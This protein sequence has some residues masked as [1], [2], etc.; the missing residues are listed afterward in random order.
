M[1]VIGAGSFGRTIA[2]LL[3]INSNVLLYS[4]SPLSRDVENALQTSPARTFS[5][6]NTTSIKDFCRSCKVIFPIV[7]SANFRDMTRSF[8]SELHP[9]HILIHGTKGFD[10]MGMDHSEKTWIRRSNMR[11][12]SQVIR[13][14]TQVVRIGCMSGPNL[15]VEIEK[16]LPAAT[17]VASNYNEVVTIGHSLLNSPRFRVYGSHDL[18]GTEL[19]G[20]L[21]NMIAVATGITHGMGLGKNIDALLITRGLREIIV[22]GEKLGATPTTFIG[23]AGLGDLIATCTSTDSRNF[24]FG[25]AIGKGKSIDEIRASMSELVEG[26]RTIKLVYHL[27]IAEDLEVP[28]IE[29]LYFILF[30][31]LPIQEA[32]SYLLNYPYSMDVDYI[33]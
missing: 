16:G 18:L 22:V 24:R 5:I 6:R 31:G 29:I 3:S 12:M 10:L 32:M 21:K 11:T 17:V 33:Q 19:G 23:T 9:Y 7:P 26:E 8:A 15:S 25:Q 13:E 14:E 20:A 1:G 2:R 27:A 28:I 30:R 4:R